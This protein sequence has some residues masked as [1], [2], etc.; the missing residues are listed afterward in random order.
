VANPTRIVLRLA[1]TRDARRHEQCLE[2]ALTER[3]KSE[4][5]DAAFH[6]HDLGVEHHFSTSEGRHFEL[7]DFADPSARMRAHGGAAD[8]HIHGT[9]RNSP[10]ADDDPRR[11]GER[12]SAMN[13]PFA[14]GL[15]R[16]GHP[17]TLI[18]PE[19]KQETCQI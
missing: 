12:P 11:R 19:G 4:R 17:K 15:C 10:A 16:L 3:E 5:Q 13:A 6:A 1:S 7:H 8:R 2:R 18:T 14:P 9:D